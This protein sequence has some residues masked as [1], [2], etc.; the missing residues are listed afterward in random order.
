[1]PAGIKDLTSLIQ[2]TCPLSIHYKMFF[3]RHKLHFLVIGLKW[4]ALASILQVISKSTPLSFRSQMWPA[5]FDDVRFSAWP[6]SYMCSL[7]LSLNV[8]YVRPVYVSV[9]LLTFSF[10]VASYTKSATPQFPPIGQGVLHLQGR[11]SLCCFLPRILLLC[12]ATVEAILGI[13]L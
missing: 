1:M 11:G 10:T 3:L 4:V 8:R 12:M 13:H 6:M 5:N 9:L 7:Y 2:G